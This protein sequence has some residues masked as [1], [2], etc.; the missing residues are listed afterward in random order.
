MH[1][2]VSLTKGVDHCATVAESLSCNTLCWLQDKTTTTETQGM[3]V[4]YNVSAIQSG[5]SC[6]C[7]KQAV[8]HAG[9]PCISR[10]HRDSKPASASVCAKAASAYVVKHSSVREMRMCE[11][12]ACVK[13]MHEGEKVLG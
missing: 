3:S 4:R 8:A 1:H 9:E 7:S 5:T 11:S 2:H 6:D 10:P 13:D 12:S